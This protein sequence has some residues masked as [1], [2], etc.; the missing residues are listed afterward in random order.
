MQFA[1]GTI[2][3][4][5]LFPPDL[6]AQLYNMGSP[7][8]AA[9]GSLT[10]DLY[11]LNL[12]SGASGAYTTR[13]YLSTDQTITTSDL[14]LNTFSVP[15]ETAYNG[16]HWFDHYNYAQ[17]LPS[18]LAPGTYWLGAIADYDNQIAESNESNNTYNVVQ[19][20]VPAASQPDLSAQLYN[21][22]S[23]TVA[24]GGSL[25]V[26]LYTLNL[27]SGASGAYTTR[28]YLSTDQTITTSDTLLTTLSVP[29]ETAYNGSHWFDH[30]NYAQALPSNLAPG[31]YWLGAIADY[32]NQIAES[33]ES[34]NTYNVVQ[35]TVPS[36]SGGQ[37]DL[38][39]QLYNMGSPT[40]AAAAV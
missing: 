21:M 1:D 24:A 36:S 19:V 20:T 2:N 11:T 6:S 7:T 13:L 23:P 18:N 37:P 32:D 3:T 4:S 31:T 28:L 40:V 35:V 30:Y 34:N 29:A 15:A 16:S 17:A 12:G 33:N 39:A 26:D 10:V 38:S 27:G 22:G 8:V 25:T 14:L 5:G 9:G